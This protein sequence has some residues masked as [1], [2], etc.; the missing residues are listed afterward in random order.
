[1]TW[2]GFEP[3]VYYLS[4]TYEKGISV[5][6]QTLAEFRVDWYPSLDLPKWAITI[7]PS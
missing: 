4:G 7:Q 1:M 2:K 5:D 3:I 6:S